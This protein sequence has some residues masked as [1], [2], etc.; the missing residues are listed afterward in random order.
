[1]MLLSQTGKSTKMR[2][3]NKR[4][5]F[6]RLKIVLTTT[7]FLR[8]VPIKYWGVPKRITFKLRHQ[9]RN[10]RSNNSILIKKTRT[11]T[12][13]NSRCRPKSVLMTPPRTSARGPTHP[14]TRRSAKKGNSTKF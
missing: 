9:M 5:T 12:R 6:T 2:R 14:T 1:M 10:N 8:M 3:R 13:R 11:P 7:T 4:S